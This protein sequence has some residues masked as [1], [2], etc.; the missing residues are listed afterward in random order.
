M[1]RV[2]GTIEDVTLEHDAEEKLRHMERL[3]SVGKLT[4]G[5]AH[6]FN[7]LLTV[8]TA[9]AELLASLPETTQDQ[10]H[11]VDA[12]RLAAGRGADL[13]S[14]LLSFSRKKPLA[15]KTIDVGAVVGETTDLLRRTLPAFIKL[16]STVDLRNWTVEADPTQINTALLNLVVNSADALSSGGRISIEVDCLAVGDVKSEGIPELR[17]VDYVRISV[18][19]DGAGMSPEVL[20]RACD[21]FFTTKEIGKGSGLGL[22]MVWGFVQQ[23]GGQMVV[24]SRLYEGTRVV[25]YLPRSLAAASTYRT[26]QSDLGLVRGDGEF[27]LVV[28]D[29]YMLRPQVVSMIRALN[30]NVVAMESGEEALSYIRGGAEID[31]VFTDLIMPGAV[32]GT[33]LID[34]VRRLYP[35]LKVLLT[36]GYADDAIIGKSLADDSLSFLAK[37]Y[38]MQ[39]LSVKLRQVL[40]E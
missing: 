35:G 36:S 8:I 5:V 14:S 37:P 29:D 38:K 25:L 21:P 11:L 40:Q 22:S 34:E 17:C 18:I 2:I 12:I 30:Y 10:G 16:C 32:S 23:S 3:E 19:D 33:D 20:R 1:R 27:V 9:S 28:E 39:D 15:P 13:T 6:D 26:S 24:R 7:N 4:G 31:L